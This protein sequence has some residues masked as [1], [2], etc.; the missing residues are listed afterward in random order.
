MVID[1]STLA[2]LSARK[3]ELVTRHWSDKHHQVV[4][5]INLITLL[6]T[7]DDRKIPVD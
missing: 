4:S 6:R 7:D 1:D 3:I 2:E 5:G